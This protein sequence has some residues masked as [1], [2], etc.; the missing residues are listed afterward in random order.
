[1]SD[2]KP[3]PQAQ[4][5]TAGP[6]VRRTAS[7]ET[8]PQYGLPSEDA[9]RRSLEDAATPLPDGWF[10]HLDP[11]SNHH[12]YVDMNST[13]PRSVWLHPR[14]DA[15][16]PPLEEISPSTCR[17][18]R[19]GARRSWRSSKRSSCS[20]KRTAGHLRVRRKRKRRRSWRDMPSDARRSWR[21]FSGMGRNSW[22]VSTSGR[23]RPRMRART[24]GGV[25][26]PAWK[27][28]SLDGWRSSRPVFFTYWC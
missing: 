20:L 23:L 21:R 2:T 22:G 26:T 6:S 16:P 27:L 17:P 12:Y 14:H 28:I 5:N 1:M 4:E 3:P 24:E 9:R 7:I 15:P 10:C 11:H 8:L 25:Q 18:H 13:P 19:P